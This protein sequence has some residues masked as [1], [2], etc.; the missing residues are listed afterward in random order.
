MPKTRPKIHQ[1]INLFVTQPLKEN[2]Y[3]ILNTFSTKPLKRFLL[4]W[5]KRKKTLNFKKSSFSPFF[6][7]WRNLLIFVVRRR[8]DKYKGDN[9][10]DLFAS[11]WKTVKIL[12]EPQLSGILSPK[13]TEN[14]NIYLL[15][16]HHRR[17]TLY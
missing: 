3:A 15:I 12:K 16:K 14:I 1:S 8:Q 9:F 13:N 6:L 2:I 10:Y 17:T 5:E 4:D 7:N 11:R